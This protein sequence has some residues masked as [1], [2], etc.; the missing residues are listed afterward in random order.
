[1]AEYRVKTYDVQPPFDLEEIRCDVC[2]FGIIDAETEEGETSDMPLVTTG[3]IYHD[4]DVTKID[5]VVV[6][7]LPV[8][9]NCPFCFSNRFRTGGR[10]GSL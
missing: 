5:K 4:P 8:G 7:V 1:M 10:R 6:S 9:I 2:G 3:T